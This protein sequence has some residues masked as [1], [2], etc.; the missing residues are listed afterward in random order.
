MDIRQK[1]FHRFKGRFEKRTTV[2]RKLTEISHIK[3]SFFI[4]Q[5]IVSLLIAC[6]EGISLG[7][8]VPLSRGLV[9]GK[10]DF[11]LNSFYSRPFRG[12]INEKVHSPADMFFLISTVI[13]FFALL[14]NISEYC[15]KVYV[16]RNREQFIFSMKNSV[17]ERLL[18]F[19]K[20]YFDRTS[21]GQLGLYIGWIDDLFDLL[22]RFSYTVIAY[23]TLFVY[24]CIM[25]FISWKMT[26][27]VLLIFPALYIGTRK[28]IALIHTGGKDQTVT[29]MSLFREFY[30]VFS[31][32]AL[33]KTSNKEAWVKD[34]FRQTLTQLKKIN[35]TLFSRW[36][37][38]PGIQ[39]LILLFWLLSFIWL[40]AFI[41]AK[42]NPSLM[43]GYVIMLV[44]I[45]KSVPLFGVANE[46]RAAVGRMK[47]PLRK[48]IEL[49]SDKDKYIFAL[50]DTEFAGL[51]SS[52]QMHNVSFSYV[53]GK[54]V[55]RYLS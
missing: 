4:V 15:L 27:L 35:I 45:R 14:K 7:L 42:Q 28:I 2:L 8:L 52:I 12:L 51:R 47:E 40:S 19:G 21:Q 39:E 46:F 48:I 38:I 18:S 37:L 29:N 9:E 3:A 5:F 43:I 10:Y 44:F 55:L 31:C 23:C 49:F 50:G 33:V 32:I 16:I 53:P 54:E 1:L 11:L 36:A 25:S 34:R 30:N 41:F 26:L 17:I 24:M 22:D 6:F 20:L 13:V